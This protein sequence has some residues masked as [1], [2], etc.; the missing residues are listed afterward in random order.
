LEKPFFSI[1][2]LALLLGC[3]G[4]IPDTRYP[5]DARVIREVPVY[6]DTGHQCGPSSLA[7]VIN[8]WRDTFNNPVSVTPEGISSEVYSKDAGG[9]LGMDLE[10]YARSKGFEARQYAGGIEDLK[11]NIL[12]E[13]PPVILV[14]YGIFAYQRNHFMVVTGYT[15]NG[16]I[17]HSGSREKIIRFDELKRIWEKTGFWTLV[18]KP[19]DWRS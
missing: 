16:I 14:D 8:Y 6:E 11:K 15:G 3:A 18:V 4:K 19:W 1:F 10:F 2:L 5:A 9:T 17:V 13:I 12:E 7:A